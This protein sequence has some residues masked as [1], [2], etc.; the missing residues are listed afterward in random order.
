MVAFDHRVVDGADAARF[1]GVVKQA[2]EAPE[3]MLLMM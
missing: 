2:M 3:N 1:M